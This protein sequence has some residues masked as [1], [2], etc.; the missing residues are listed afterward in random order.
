MKRT[1]VILA[2]LCALTLTAC[3]GDT[4]GT[5]GE[6]STAL[7]TDLA[8]GTVLEEW[9]DHGGFHGDGARWVELSLSGADPAPVFSQEAG[10]HATPL[11][12]ELEAVWYGVT[13][14]TDQG[15]VSE[16]PYLPEGVSV[17]QVEEGYWFFQD[18]H[19]EA[20]DP[21]DPSD[22]FSRYSYNFTAALYDAAGET[23]YYYE[24]D[25]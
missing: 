17:P 16:G 18:R 24:L 15:E 12:E 14:Q 21:G 25:T 4:Q 10:W 6:L 11:P 1:L 20:E 13:R 9:D 23:L 5:L 19:G 22:L 3:T 7:G 8:Q 2:L